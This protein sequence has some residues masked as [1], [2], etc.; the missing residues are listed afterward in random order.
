MEI[1][2]LSLSCW[3]RYRKREASASYLD[4]IN[5]NKSTTADWPLVSFDRISMGHS[6]RSRA[7]VP[8][9]PLED[10]L[11]ISVL[12]GVFR[13][14]AV[15]ARVS[16]ANTSIDEAAANECAMIWIDCVPDTAGEHKV[17]MFW[18]MASNENESTKLV[19]FIR[20]NAS[21]EN[22]THPALAPAAQHS[23]LVCWEN[24][25]WSLQHQVELQIGGSDA[26]E[27]LS[28]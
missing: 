10:V 15:D 27:R 14:E 25:K 8:C 7:F 17:R 22:E 12:V 23:A 26:R 21:C 5:Q 24:R 3:W 4:A 1:Q 11:M 18:I 2:L 20:P 6:N 19:C 9:L 16:G 13:L 28:L